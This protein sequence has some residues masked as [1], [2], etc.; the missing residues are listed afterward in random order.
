MNAPQESVRLRF[1]TADG[2]Q[3]QAALWR[4]AGAAGASRRLLLVAPGFA[5]H[6]GTVSMRLLAGSLSAFSDTLVMA[7]RGNGPSEGRYTFGA[8]EVLDLDAA[9]A[10]AQGEYTQIELLGF[11]LGAYTVVRACADRPAKVDGILLVSCP[12]CLQDIVLSGGALL[13]PLVLP[14]RRVPYRH[15]PQNDLGFRWGWPFSRQPNLVKIAPN[16]SLPCHFLATTGDTLVFSRLTRRVYEAW[17]GPKSWTSFERGIHAE[18]MFHQFPERFISWVKTS[19]NSA[20]DV[21]S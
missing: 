21:K 3:V 19:A 9:L 13:N 4:H 17:G 5:Q 7:F 10:W 15:P 18:H 14:F 12:T 8:K 1:S 16:I 20:A 6:F 11:S 2:L